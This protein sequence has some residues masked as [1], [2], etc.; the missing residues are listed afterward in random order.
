MKLPPNLSASFVPD[1]PG[2]N[3]SEVVTE[4]PAAILPRRRGREVVVAAV[5][6]TALLRAV[7]DAVR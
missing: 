4:V 7:L 6:R 3:V 2:G 1:V 5:P